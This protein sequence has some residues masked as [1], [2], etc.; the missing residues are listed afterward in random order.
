MDEKI[1]EKIK[2]LLSLADS[3]N[4]HEARAAL[5]K[6]RELMAKYKIDRQGA[7]GAKGQEV[8]TRTAKPTYSKR[9]N[10][11]LM[12]LASVIAEHYCCKSCQ[13]RQKGKQTYMTVFIGFFDDVELCTQ[14]FAY[15]YGCIQSGIQKIRQKNA[16]KYD[17]KTIKSLCESYGHGYVDGI[18]DAFDAQQKEADE[19]GWGLVLAIPKEVA[20]YA[21]RLYTGAV[22]TK[23][24]VDTDAYERGRKHGRKFDPNNKLTG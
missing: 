23:M 5:L 19:A 22:R 14:V 21:D 17:A 9:R 24:L 20:E 15:A 1:Q 7:D 4:E 8:V 13:R 2:K 18:M 16:A 3:P 6:A 12:H 10:P 11:W